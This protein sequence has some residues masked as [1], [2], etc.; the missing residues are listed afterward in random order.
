MLDDAALF[1]HIAIGVGPQGHAVAVWPGG[2]FLR[3]AA[4]LPGGSFGAPVSSGVAALNPPESIG[5]D[6]QGRTIMMLHPIPVR[7]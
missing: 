5:V 1:G 6:G 7:L 3:S 4:R 2:G